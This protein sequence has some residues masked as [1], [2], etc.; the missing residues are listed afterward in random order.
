MSTLK[1]SMIVFH[2]GT[3]EHG[4]NFHMKIKIRDWHDRKKLQSFTRYVPLC[5]H[6]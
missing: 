6:K 1:F 3:H 2:F 5:E 4:K